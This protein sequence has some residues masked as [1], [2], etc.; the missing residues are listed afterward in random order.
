[1]CNWVPMLYSGEKK[2]CWGNENFKKSIYK[3][4]KND[5]KLGK[6]RNTQFNVFELLGRQA[7]KEVIKIYCDVIQSMAS[8]STIRVG[9]F[10]HSYAEE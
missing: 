10:R 3:I 2:L 7:W 8:F 6:K 9:P 4:S 5:S 1:M